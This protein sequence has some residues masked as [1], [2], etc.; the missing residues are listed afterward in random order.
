[1]K[2]EFKIL[3]MDNLLENNRFPLVTDIQGNVYGVDNNNIINIEGT[4]SNP[5][6]GEVIGTIT[7]TRFVNGAIYKVTAELK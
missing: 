7:N 4:L 5:K 6:M 1:M 2:K 3:N